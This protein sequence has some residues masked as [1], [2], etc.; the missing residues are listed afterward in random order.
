ML[1]QEGHRVRDTKTDRNIAN[2]IE[3]FEWKV[4][5]VKAAERLGPF[6][7]FEEE[8]ETRARRAVGNRR[9]KGACLWV[10]LRWGVLRY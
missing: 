6:G 8:V 2:E 3:D 1:R 9:I 4:E 7:T 5:L 10:D